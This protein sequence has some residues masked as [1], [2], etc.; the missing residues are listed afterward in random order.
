[1][2]TDLDAGVVPGGQDAVGG[3]ALPGDVHVHV[4]SGFVLHGGGCEATLKKSRSKFK[5]GYSATGYKSSD[6]RRPR[7]PPRPPPPWLP[8]R[9]FWPAL[10]PW[11]RRLGEREEERIVKRRMQRQE[12]S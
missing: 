8:P 3:A 10:K 4:F 5:T 6:H 2:R 12:E 1:M 7:F 9:R 11:E